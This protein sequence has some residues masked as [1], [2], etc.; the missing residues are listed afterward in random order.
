MWIYIVL[1][2]KYAVLNACFDDFFCKKDAILEEVFG[3][4]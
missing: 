4:I 1:P 2:E 3:I